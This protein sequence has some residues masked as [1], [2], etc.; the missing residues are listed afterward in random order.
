MKKIL[1]RLFL[2]IVM[3]FGIIPAT[4]FNNVKEDTHEVEAVTFN[5]GGMIYFNKPSDSN[6][7][8]M[9]DSS[10][11]VMFII[12]KSNWSSA[13]TMQNISGTNL[14]YYNLSGWND[15]TYCGFATASAKWGDGNW[16]DSNLKNGIAYT[17]AYKG[18]YTINGG[19]RYLFT[20]SSSSNGAT[21]TVEYKSDNNAFKSVNASVETHLSTDK[22]LTYS[23]SS[24]G[25][26][27]KITSYYLSS[28]NAA[29]SSSVTSSSGKATYNCVVSSYTTFT[30]T[31]SSGYTFKGWYD[32][33]G[34]KISS[35]S[36]YQ[37][38]TPTTV[39]YYARFVKN[40]TIDV[41]FYADIT[42]IVEKFNGQIT[43]PFIHYWSSTGQSAAAEFGSLTMDKLGDNLYKRVVTLNENM[44]NIVGINFGFY[45]DSVLKQTTG[46]TINPTITI[47]DAGKEF[48]IVIQENLTWQTGVASPQITGGITV[49]K[50]IPVKYYDGNE[51]VGSGKIY[52]L[53]Y[54]PLFIEKE[55]YKL[56][57]W[58]LSDGS[59]HDTKTKFPSTSNIEEYVLYS[60][61]EK[62]NDYY[63][64]VDTLDKPW[65][66][67]SVYMWSNYFSLENG[68][69]HKND[70]FPGV[71]DAEIVTDI[72][73]KMYKIKIDASKSYNHLI[74]ANTANT[75][76]ASHPKQ[77]IDLELTPDKNYYVFTKEITQNKNDTYC[78]NVRY[79]EETDNFLHAQK[80][81]SSDVNDFR[82]IA[83]F[84]NKT[85][86]NAFGGAEADLTTKQFGYK[87]IF[88][89]GESSYVGYWN[90]NKDYKYNVIRY[91][92]T[93]Y[94]SVDSTGKTGDAFTEIENDYS[95]FYALSLKDGI[96]FKYSD[97]EQI[98]VVACYRDSDNKVQVI[99]AQEYN[100]VTN[101]G[102][103][104][105][106][107]IER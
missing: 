38:C 60:N 32:S 81:I 58:K 25:G 76:D 6:S 44:D 28:N 97:Y 10:S 106:T 43:N 62:A 86:A 96:T 101:N 69:T 71:D 4:S 54:N 72:G 82:F 53:T 48:R 11:V 50:V 20:P 1:L 51:L 103:I 39:T 13:Y 31:A 27:A 90:F 85:E 19:S 94:E 84:K 3:F 93:L 77:T 88:V 68:N 65:S 14:Y 7:K 100:I 75:G 70:S 2:L 80:N 66:S 41:I 73:N 9:S 67:F 5:N 17:A 99:K 107:E 16:N 104:Y 26:S 95:E 57:N 78:Y 23:L 92:G 37:V 29:A 15:A 105:L 30:A 98:I 42:N 36:E 40:Y 18:N 91:E 46:I 64:Y 33:Q 47:S 74:F 59:L 56:N 89:K 24:T 12:G 83:G 79:E 22:G 8:W 34:N 87:F 35:N 45:E 55:G 102:T 21:L 61:Y 49:G 52:G 63:I